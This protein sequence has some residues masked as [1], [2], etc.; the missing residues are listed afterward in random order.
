[1]PY[2]R[3]QAPASS[4]VTVDEARAWCRI[5]DS[6]DD[7]QLSMLIGAATLAAETKTRRALVNQQ[8]RLILDSFPGPSL[9]WVPYGKTYGIPAHA[10]QIHKCPV[11]SIDVIRY[12]DMAGVWQTVDP[13]VYKSD[14]SSEPARIT[15]VFGRIWP[16]NRPE[17]GSVQVDFTAGY[18]AAA[19][20]P[21]GLKHWIAMRV[22]TMYEM[23][24][25]VAV[26][27]RGTVQELP[28]VDSLLDPYLVAE[29]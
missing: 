5:P 3:L 6:S 24:E 1:M 23:R 25:E 20:V 14:L 27:S 2:Q 22:S 12:Q 18:G 10:I 11:V 19:D 7:A 4:P 21:E 16:I 17:I 15:P 8:W 26:M 29:F 13:S 28:Y 9:I